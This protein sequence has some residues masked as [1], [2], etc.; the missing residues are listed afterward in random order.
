MGPGTRFHFR[1][2]QN[3]S[4]QKKLL[5]TGIIVVLILLFEAL[6]LSRVL[7]NSPMVY[8]GIHLDGVS[9]EGLDKIELSQYINKKYNVDMSSLEL[10]IYHKNYPVTIRFDELEVHIDKELI[11]NKVYSMGRQGS[12]FKR[13]VDIYKLGKNHVFLETEVSVNTQ[14]LDMLINRIYE[15]TYIPSESPSLFLLDNEVVLSSGK[16]GYIINKELLKERI[17]KQISKLESG[18]VI[19]PVEKIPPVKIEADTM[20]N[21][22][23]RE[24]QNASVIRMDGEIEIIP[25]VVGRKLDKAEFLS[26]VAEMEAKSAKYPM[27]LKL[28]V[29]FVEPEITEEKIKNSL[30]SD[31]LSAYSS[32]FSTET[33]NDKNRS[34]NIR[35]AVE[36][37]NGT[38]LLPGETFS[39]NEVVGQRT[40][41]KGYLPANIY[42]PDGISTGVGGGVCQVSSTL[43]NAA[44]RANLKIDER[45]PHIFMVAYVPLGCDATV[46]YGIQDFKFTNN[47]NWPVR[48]DG[49]VTSDNKLEFSIAGTDEN[50]SLEVVV[51]S[52]VLKLIPYETEYIETDKLPEGSRKL[53][54]KGMNGAVVEAYLIVK[55]GNEVMSNYK[56]HSTTYKSLPEIIQT[57]KKG[58]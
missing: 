25:E 45:N 46:S 23:V 50:P 2:F 33:E 43:Y 30:F 12:F 7:L 39:F 4:K 3:M 28:P 18:I 24:P 13:L 26:L 42:T 40:A 17:L 35:L 15:N 48:I 38:I 47:T 27:D 52:T 5:L 34:V 6:Y 21:R 8:S 56:L 36:A 49:Q 14:A 1:N 57:G 44:L 53:I 11:L 29:D 31:I 54:Q 22:I 10:S 55:K 32:E 9:L 16:P 51:Q 41:Q 37:I 19:V 58:N 20:Y